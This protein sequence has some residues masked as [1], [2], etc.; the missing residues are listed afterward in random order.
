MHA[1][2]TVGT[3]GDGSYWLELAILTFVTSFASLASVPLRS[4]RL[5]R[6]LETP[7]KFNLDSEVRRQKENYQPLLPSKFILSAKNMY[8]LCLRD[9]APQRRLQH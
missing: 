1:L 7:L 2:S 5:L 3:I 6:W 4:L 9:V 8:L